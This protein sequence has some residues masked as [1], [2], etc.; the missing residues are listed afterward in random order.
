M[1][2]PELDDQNTVIRYLLYSDQFTT[3]GL[4]YSGSGVHWAG[5]GKGT[6]WFVPG[7]EYTRSG[8]KDI[9][10]VAGVVG[11]PLAPAGQEAFRRRRACDVL[12]F[13]FA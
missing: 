4:V 13:K 3:E 5:D 6:K 1:N 11:T 8:L 7:R 2:D 12:V 10:P 9:C